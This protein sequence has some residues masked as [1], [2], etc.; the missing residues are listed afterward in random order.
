MEAAVLVALGIIVLV[1][2][3]FLIPL[4]LPGIWIMI[5]VVAIGAFYDEVSLGT[6][7]A[8]VAVATAAEI[9]EFFLVKHYN[10]RYGGSRLAFWGALVGGVVGVFVGTPIPVIGSIVAG[11]IGTFAGAAIATLWET[12]HLP[13]AAR[14]GWGV[15]LARIVATAVKTAAGVVIL[16]V[17]AGALLIG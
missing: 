9:A 11:V 13:T 10:V 4:G 8:L 5:G 16:V 3:L 2:S 15:A 7:I 1:I 6:L 14:V 12:R 17:G